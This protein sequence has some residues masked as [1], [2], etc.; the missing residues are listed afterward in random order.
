LVEKLYIYTNRGQNC[1]RQFHGMIYMYNV[2]TL[3]EHRFDT[4]S[5][6]KVKVI[7]LTFILL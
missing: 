2:K 5:F 6:F 3:P 1:E 4:I 7:K